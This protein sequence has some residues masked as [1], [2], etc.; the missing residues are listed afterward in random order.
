MKIE[1]KI[2]NKELE[3]LL[4]CTKPNQGR[5]THRNLEVIF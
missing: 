5:T 2:L 1:M 3:K 4:T